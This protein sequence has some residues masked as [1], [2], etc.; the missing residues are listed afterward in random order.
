[1]ESISLFFDIVKFA[2]LRK[3]SHVE[4]MK[5]A[6]VSRTQGVCYAFFLSNLGKVKLCQL[7]S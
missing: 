7:S 3:N 4:K 2:D 1:M 5:I 6:D